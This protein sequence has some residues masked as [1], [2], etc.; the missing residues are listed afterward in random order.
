LLAGGETDYDFYYMGPIELY[1]PATGQFTS[2]GILVTPRLF[3][4][5]T[6]LPDGTVLIA[7]GDNDANNRPTTATE[8]YDP[9]TGS[10]TTSVPMTQA[11]VLHAATSLSDGSVLFTGG[12][13]S[14]PSAEIYH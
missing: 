5:A 10:F 4:T 1:D 7:G 6:L 2:T 8:I 12:S 11:R 13:I 14:D 3:H 9:K